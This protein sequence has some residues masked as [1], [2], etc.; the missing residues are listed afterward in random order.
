MFWNI[1]NFNLF[2]TDLDCENILQISSSPDPEQH[3]SCQPLCGGPHHD[4]PPPTILHQS[5]PKRSSPW[6]HRSKGQKYLTQT[7]QC[8]PGG[9]SPLGLWFSLNSW[10]DGSDLAVDLPHCGEGLGG[11]VHLPGQAAQGE[12]WAVYIHSNLSVRGWGRIRYLGRI[13]NFWDILPF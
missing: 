1:F 5:L 13:R 8:W 4:L 9:W 3:S 6:H 10:S 2:L 11:L 12:H 7:G